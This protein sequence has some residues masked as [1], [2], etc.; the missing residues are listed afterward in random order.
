MIQISD[1]K[2]SVLMQKWYSMVNDLLFPFRH[3]RAFF[4]FRSSG[5]SEPAVRRM[6]AWN[7][8]WLCVNC[9][10]AQWV[11]RQERNINCWVVWSSPLQKSSLSPFRKK[12]RFMNTGLSKTW[13]SS[14]WISFV[15]MRRLISNASVKLLLLLDYGIHAETM[16]SSMRNTMSSGKET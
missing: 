14:F 4:Y 11:T 3:F 12:E 2:A 10:S 9:L 16:E 7:S 8:I 15:G 5:L 1:I 6:T 13:V